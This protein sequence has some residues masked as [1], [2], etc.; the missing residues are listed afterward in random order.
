MIFFL[1][2]ILSNSLSSLGTGAKR[3]QRARV[4]QRLDG[5]DA[6]LEGAARFALDHIGGSRQQRDRVRGGAADL[7]RRGLRRRY[8]RRQ[9]HHAR[10][11]Q[12]DAGDDVVLRRIAMP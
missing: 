10:R 2:S 12:R 11:Q 1:S 9:S 8:V 4:T 3:T 6:V 7:L 5:G